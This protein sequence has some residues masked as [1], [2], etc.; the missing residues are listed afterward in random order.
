MS[1]IREVQLK[2]LEILKNFINICQELEIDYWLDSGTLLGAIRHKGFIPWDDDIDIGI[3]KKDIE[4]LISYFKKN[5]G[6]YIL[7]NNAEIDKEYRFYKIYQKNKIKL[8]NGKEIKIFIDIFP[9]T[10][11]PKDKIFN[12][13]NY[14]YS[15]QKYK[16]NSLNC[17]FFLRDIYVG[18]IKNL[19]KILFLRKEKL[20][21]FLR[22]R[23][24]KIEKQEKKYF[25]YVYD[26]GF[27]LYLLKKEDFFPLKKINF[28]GIEMNIPN[29]YE[30]VLNKLYGDYKVLPPKNKRKPSHFKNFDL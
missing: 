2:T 6:N 19:K 21:S 8:S 3:H 18:I 25:Y 22:K 23:L 20:L 17:K 7:V 15:I 10:D 27:S 12:F 26:I 24:N 1:E 30:L 29:N 13:I 9:Y 11:Y 4:K 14:F 16:V 5:N 28:E